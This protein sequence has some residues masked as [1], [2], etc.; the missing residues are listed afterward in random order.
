M[1]TDNTNKINFKSWK[2]FLTLGYYSS[3]NR[4]AIKLLSDD[5]NADKGVFYGEHIA[6]ATINI[7]EIPLDKNEIIVKE[8]SEN[9]GMLEALRQSGLISD[10]KREVSTGFVTVHV[11]E[12]T[13]KLIK[14]EK[15]FKK[16]L[17]KM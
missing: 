13:P 16:S 5:E 3:G 9:S 8:H 10:T 2:C 15:E 11:V 6:T 7:P 14:M 12:K 17:P 4:L 1:T